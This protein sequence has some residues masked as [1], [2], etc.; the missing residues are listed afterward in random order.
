ME[1]SSRLR[2]ALFL[3]LAPQLRLPP[4]PVALIGQAALAGSLALGR[5]GDRV[6][7]VR[8][9]SP[10]PPRLDGFL[11]RLSRDQGIAAR[12]DQVLAAG[13]LPRLADLELILRL[14]EIH[15]APRTRGI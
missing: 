10:A 6:V 8:V 15:C 4:R 5:I 14:V 1:P 9:I 2:F 3:P 12:T 7:M 13:L 11:R